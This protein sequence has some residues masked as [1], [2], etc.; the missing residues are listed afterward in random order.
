MYVDEFQCQADKSTFS[1]G[2]G[3]AIG[4]VMKKARYKRKKKEAELQKKKERELRLAEERR[5][6]PV[7][8]RRRMFEHMALIK[9]RRDFRTKQLQYVFPEES[10]LS[11]LPVNVEDDDT[12]SDHDNVQNSPEKE[13]LSE[14]VPFKHNR[15][16]S[17][18]L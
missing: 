15:R 18:Y 7:E 8:V 6:R 13:Q 9:K 4:L 3:L 2:L 5:S 10:K 17:K 12:F 1:V 16:L 14:S 11:S